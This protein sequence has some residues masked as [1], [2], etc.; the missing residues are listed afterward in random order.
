METEDN[1]AQQRIQPR[2][3]PSARRSDIISWIA[4][5]WFQ[6]SLHVKAAQG[7]KKTG[8]S[9]DLTGSEDAEIVREAGQ[10]WRKLGM[11]ERRAKVLHD[12]DVEV[13]VGRLAWTYEDVYSLIV[14]HPQRGKRYDA[15]PEDEGSEPNDGSS[16]EDNEDDDDDDDNNGDKK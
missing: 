2:C 1:I 8:M 11:R 14:P 3:C 15:Q 9:N 6:T 13:A 5:I 12:V 10:F 7:F 4:C 16:E